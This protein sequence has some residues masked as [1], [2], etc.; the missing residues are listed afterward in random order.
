MHN[1]PSPFEFTSES[2][3]ETHAFGQAIGQVV[4]PGS[5]IALIGDLGAGKTCLVRGV[6]DGLQIDPKLVSS[7]TFVL[8]QEYS[9]RLPLFHF[10]T[11]RLQSVDE[12]VDLGVEEYFDAGGVCVIEWADR[13]DAV[14]PDDVLQIDIE[15]CGAAQRRFRLS[16]RGTGSAEVLAA[17][18]DTLGV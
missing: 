17:L 13:V 7:P 5:V 1:P 6:A 11:Y 15:I 4:T 9:G 8:I 12:F 14:L 16:A 2:D 10:D 18:I 3:R